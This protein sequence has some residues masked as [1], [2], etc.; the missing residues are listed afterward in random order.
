M[1]TMA[2]PNSLEQTCT[3]AKGGKNGH[4]AVYQK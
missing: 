1:A 2:S 4:D 3:I